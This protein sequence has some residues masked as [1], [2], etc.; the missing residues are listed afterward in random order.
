[1]TENSGPKKVMR[2]HHTRPLLRTRETPV[3]QTGG[4]EKVWGRRATVKHRGL[5]TT[6]AQPTRRESAGSGHGRHDP[7]APRGWPTPSRRY[8]VS[9]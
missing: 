7:R 9:R 5:P 6:R 2:L 4:G 8:L 3:K 1:M